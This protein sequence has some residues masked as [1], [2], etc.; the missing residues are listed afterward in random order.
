MN[1]IL[2]YELKNSITSSYAQ[3]NELFFNN[4][5][6]PLTTLIFLLF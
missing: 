1:N 3:F 4:F 2:Y 5:I 6:M